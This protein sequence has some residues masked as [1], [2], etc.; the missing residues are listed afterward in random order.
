MSMGIYYQANRD[1]MLSEA[2]DAK[3]DKITHQYW[4]EYPQK[5]KFEGPGTFSNEEGQIYSGMIRIPLD[6]SMEEL[7][8][9]F[10]Y[11]LKWLTDITRVLDDAKWEAAFEGVPLIWEET[12]WRFMSDE[13]YGEMDRK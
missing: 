2:E 7:E 9:F 6:F 3:I 13:E 1:V 10:T 5:E 4:E 12:G 8:E 11:W